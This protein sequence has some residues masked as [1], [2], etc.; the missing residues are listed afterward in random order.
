MYTAYVI[1][2]TFS[3]FLTYSVLQSK[4]KICSVLIC[5]HAAHTYAKSTHT[6]VCYRIAAAFNSPERYQRVLRDVLERE[7]D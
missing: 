4:A 3:F 5:I 1:V 7:S 6:A 2:H